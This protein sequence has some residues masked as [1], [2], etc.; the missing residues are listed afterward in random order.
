MIRQWRGR[1]FR[2][3][4]QNNE[5]YLQRNL[6]R[7]AVHPRGIPIPY[8]CPPFLPRFLCVPWFYI[9][10]GLCFSIGKINQSRSSAGVSDS[11]VYFPF[12]C[13]SVKVSAEVKVPKIRGERDGWTC[14]RVSGCESLCGSGTCESVCSCVYLDRVILYSIVMVIHLRF[15]DEDDLER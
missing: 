11:L 6:L 2:G 7:S 5:T 10:S 13:L 9:V 1:S 4:Y 14:V 12:V 3:L 8:S 15:E